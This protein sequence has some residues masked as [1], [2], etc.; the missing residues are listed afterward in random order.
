MKQG[1]NTA[2][3]AVLIVIALLLIAQNI[4]LF[5]RQTSTG[6]PAAEEGQWECAQT[7]CSRL[8]TPVEI[9]S[10]ICFLNEQQ[11]FVCS[12]NVDGQQGLV[13]LDEL[14]LT[15]LRLC[16]EFRCMKEVMARPV[17]YPIEAGLI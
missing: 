11:K 9:V 8:M 10:T 7:A 4:Y 13:P 6:E 12:L 16:A 17:D 3:W 2:V 1:K 5:S 15:A 14:N